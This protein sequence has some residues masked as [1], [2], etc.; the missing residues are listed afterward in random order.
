V[1]EV[2]KSTLKPFLL[3]A[4]ENELSDEDPIMDD[5]LNRG[6]N[7]MTKIVFPDKVVRHQKKVMKKIKSKQVI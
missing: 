6:R 4:F 7:A 1:T 3:E 5:V 2:L